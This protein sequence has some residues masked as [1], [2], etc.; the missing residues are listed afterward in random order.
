MASRLKPVAYLGLAGILTALASLGCQPRANDASPPPAIVAESAVGLAD[1]AAS[2]VP[3]GLFDRTPDTEFCQQRRP[4]TVSPFALDTYEVTVARFRLFL[5]A[6]YGVEGSGPARGSGAHSPSS[7]SGWRDEW[8]S[9]LAA[10]RSELEDRL[11]CALRPTWTAQA[12]ASEEL[13]INCVDWYTA[14]AFCVWD[15]GR[16]PSEAEWTFAAVGGPEGRQR[17]WG[18]GSPTDQHAVF[19]SDG[20][21]AV[22]SAEL[23]RGAWGHYDLSG[24]LW[25]WTLDRAPS[26]VL[27]PIEGADPC[28]PTG[29]PI[30]CEDCL[31]S[32]GELRVSRSG[33]WGLPAVAMRSAIRRADSPSANEHVFGIR[34]ARAATATAADRSQAQESGRDSAIDLRVVGGQWQELTEIEKTPDSRA[35]AYVLLSALTDWPTT[36]LE[37]LRAADVEVVVVLTDGERRGQPAD[38]GNVLSASEAHPGWPV[39]IDLSSSMNRSVT[40]DPCVIVVRP[41]Q[42]VI[43]CLDPSTP[44][45]E[46]SLSTVR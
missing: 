45:F 21:R 9:Q 40:T 43:E 12:G 14:F 15:G 3:G 27:L 20:A 26:G 42:E 13:P 24:N 36:L 46:A 23:G 8:N 33:G 44:D 11:D 25:E 32:E 17:P 19:G 16:L 18:S 38:I 29:M 30:P 5:D 41:G 35:R 7:N 28:D 31:G 37:S 10:D 1:S 2:T 34:C 22:G 6:G 4:A 39:A